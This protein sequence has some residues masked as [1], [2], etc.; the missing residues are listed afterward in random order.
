MHRNAEQ[1]T[2]RSSAGGSAGRQPQ[3]PPAKSQHAD[4]ECRTNRP[5]YSRSPA[6]A[7]NPSRH[8][9]FGERP[10]V[11]GDSGDPPIVR[12][13]ARSRN[14]SIAFTTHSRRRCAPCTPHRP[15]AIP[16][17]CCS[18]SPVDV[19]RHGRD[20]PRL[21]AA[22]HAADVADQRHLGHRRGRLD[23][24][25]RRRL[26]RRSSAF[27]GAIALFASMTNIVS[28]FLITDRMLK[29]FKTTKPTAEATP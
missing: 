8:N 28:G 27:S 5:F 18:S 23:H 13:A 14:I 1:L 21:A 4:A 9:R 16:G 19:H 24:R 15:P 3:S 17:R 2:Q 11:K 12:S 25:H 26:S 20:P 7:S 6:I 10:R 22:A 29:M